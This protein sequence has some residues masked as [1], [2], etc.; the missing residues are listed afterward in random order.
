[1]K[2]YIDQKI[3]EMEK[4]I[5]QSVPT[6]NKFEMASI[7]NEYREGLES[8]AQKTVESVVSEISKLAG[9]GCIGELEDI[10]VVSLTDAFS[11]LSTLKSS[12]EKR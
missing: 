11:S 3:I 9:I 5:T 4:H 12:F 2:S 1:M 10:V 8:V 6:L 7:L